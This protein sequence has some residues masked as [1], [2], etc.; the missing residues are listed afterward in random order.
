MVVLDLGPREQRC[1]VAVGLAQL[2]GVFRG[3]HTKPSR[4]ATSF[5]AVMHPSSTGD[6]I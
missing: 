5:S 1:R 4:R 2:A 6:V 3:H